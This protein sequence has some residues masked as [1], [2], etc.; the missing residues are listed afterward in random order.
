MISL[1][2]S[3]RF[4]VSVTGNR[5]LKDRLEPVNKSTIE[6]NNETRYIIV[7]QKVVPFIRKF[8]IF[9]S[10]RGIESDEMV[11]VPL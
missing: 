5:I 1:C 2:I 3:I 6:M 11:K 4:H 8:E 9:A 10:N 7:S